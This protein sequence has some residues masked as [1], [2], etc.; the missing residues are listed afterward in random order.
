MSAPELDTN[1]PGL[2]A[3]QTLESS[4]ER[5]A[6]EVRAVAADCGMEPAGFARA[7]NAVNPYDLP[8]VRRASK[9]KRT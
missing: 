6:A 2:D 9:R 5:V 4:P 7:M 3:A 1:S 8:A